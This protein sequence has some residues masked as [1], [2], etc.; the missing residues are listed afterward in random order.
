MVAG[1]GLGQAMAAEAKGRLLP[2]LPSPSLSCCS[3]G[4][5][6]GPEVPP[7]H[8]NESVLPGAGNCPAQKNPETSP[9]GLGLIL[10]KFEGEV[11][12]PSVA[13]SYATPP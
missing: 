1:R 10:F 2:C 11:L 8:R 12:Q 4:L 7:K 6:V 3:T 9:T 5:T 13:S